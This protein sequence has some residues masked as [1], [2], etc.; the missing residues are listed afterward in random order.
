ML[1]LLPTIR[2]L[3]QHLDL[4][5]DRWPGRCAT[6]ATGL[7]EMTGG[8][9]VRGHYYGPVSNFCVIPSFVMRSGQTGMPINHEW[10]SYKDGSMSDPTYWVFGHCTPFLRLQR[11]APHFYDRAGERLRREMMGRPPG[12]QDG[13]KAF[14]LTIQT[15]VMLFL[16][17]LLGRATPSNLLSLGELVWLANLPQ[18]MLSP[19]NK[20]VY[21]AI[22]AAGQRA[23]IPLDS[24]KWVMDG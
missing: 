20:A 24:W 9:A 19:Y 17:T 10:V 18:D 22:D 16:A 15:D 6:I 13:E 12:Q 8:T 11:K 14:L 4:T 23:F 2:A 7:A 3:E 1:V 5:T 21:N